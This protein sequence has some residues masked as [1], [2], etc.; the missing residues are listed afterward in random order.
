[1]SSHFSFCIRKYRGFFCFLS[2]LL[3]TSSGVSGRRVLWFCVASEVAQG[4]GRNKEYA[5]DYA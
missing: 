5:V 4:R 1:M 3:S 2:I